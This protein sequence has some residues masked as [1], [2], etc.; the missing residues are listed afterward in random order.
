MIMVVGAL[1]NT[2]GIMGDKTMASKDVYALI[3]ET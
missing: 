1:L 2:S 3:P